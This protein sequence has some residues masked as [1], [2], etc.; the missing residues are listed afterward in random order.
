MTGMNRDRPAK[1]PRWTARTLAVLGAVLLTGAGSDV[2]AQ[3]S[4]NIQAQQAQSFQRPTRAPLASGRYVSA[5]GQAFVLDFAAPRPLLRFEQSGEVFSLRATPAPRGDVIY[6]TDAGDQLLRVTPDGGVTV[7]TTRTPN[8]A[9]ASFTGP[10]GPIRPQAV[11]PIQLYNFILAQGVRI[12]RALGR[13][14]PVEM[15]IDQGSEAVAID[16]LTTTVDSLIRMSRSPQF[17]EATDEV[18]RV[19][20]MEGDRPSVTLTR[21]TLRVVI[22]PD[23]GYAGRPSSQR[24]V[25]EV[26]ERS[27]P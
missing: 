9:A 18:R 11:S 4:G 27:S 22:N 10:A 17:R 13:L 2:W 16:A 7:F 19:H 23:A 5:G 12:N 3:R 8:G 24:I 25:R 20:V 26:A 6:R 14:V 1:R 21:G 15:D